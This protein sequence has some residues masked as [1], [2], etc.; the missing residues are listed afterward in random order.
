M[1]EIDLAVPL[2]EDMQT[3]RLHILF[4]APNNGHVDVTD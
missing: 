1:D 2:R 3:R 4:I